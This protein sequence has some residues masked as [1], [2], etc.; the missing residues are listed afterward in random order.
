MTNTD[1]VEQFKTKL[2]LIMIQDEQNEFKKYLESM[3]HDYNM[4]DPWWSESQSE[5]SMGC[6]FWFAHQ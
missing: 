2:S 3:R 6:H 1:S 5:W 4:R